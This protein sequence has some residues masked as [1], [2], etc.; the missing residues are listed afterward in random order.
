[1]KVTDAPEV[2]Y[3]SGPMSHV[4][5]FNY[6]AFFEA[7]TRLSQAGYYVLNPARVPGCHTTWT[8]EMWMRESLKHLLR[9]DAVAL[10]PDWGKSRGARVE[11]HLAMNLGM[12]A[13]YVEW[14]VENVERGAA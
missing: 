6:P 14:W 8:W 2:L 12:K 9:A 5:D 1:M 3:I 11:F 10:L 13:H 7:E 4:K